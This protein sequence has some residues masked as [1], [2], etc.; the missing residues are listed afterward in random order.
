MATLGLW[1]WG[2]QRGYLLTYYLHLHQ[3]GRIPQGGVALF[4]GAERA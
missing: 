4:G 1:V 3:A 2:P